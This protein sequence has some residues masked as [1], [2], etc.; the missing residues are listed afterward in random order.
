MTAL[1]VAVAEVAGIAESLSLPYLSVSTVTLNFPLAGP[2]RLLK[3]PFETPL[4]DARG[5]VS[6]V[7]SASACRA[8]TVRGAVAGSFSA[9]C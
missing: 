4:A 9:A 7:E 3:K 6:V 5:S 2:S 1:E 8:A